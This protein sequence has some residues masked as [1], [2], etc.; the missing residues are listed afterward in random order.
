MQPPEAAA[1]PDNT[2]E[3]LAAL[4]FAAILAIAIALIAGGLV[5]RLLAKVE[6]RTQL[7][8]SM[9]KAPVRLVRL[10][11]FVVSMIGLVFPALALVGVDLPVE[12]EGEQLGQ[13]A[14][15]TALR[16]GV[17]V[18]LAITANRVVNSIVGRAELESSRAAAVPRTSSGA[19][20]RRRSRAR[21]TGS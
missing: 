10:I 4:S 12:L 17:I 15:S 18:L 3:V 13:W 21:S 16:I 7:S 6:G 19:S 11:A 1:L 14:A 9:Q 2:V 5:R 20:G 8:A